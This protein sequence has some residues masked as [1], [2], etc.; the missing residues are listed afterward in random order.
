MRLTITLISNAVKPIQFSE[1]DVLP[2]SDR[3]GA[4]LT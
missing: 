2:G 4:Y 1:Q 3:S